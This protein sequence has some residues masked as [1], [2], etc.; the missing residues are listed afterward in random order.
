MRNSLIWN[1]GDQLGQLTKGN[2]EGPQEKLPQMI[3]R[4]HDPNLI[5]M[6]SCR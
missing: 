6:V 5:A 1:R 3:E 2:D 4:I